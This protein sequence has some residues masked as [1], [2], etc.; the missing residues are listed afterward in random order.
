MLPQFPRLVRRT[1]SDENRHGWE[2][3]RSG[4]EVL[5]SFRCWPRPD[6]HDPPLPAAETLD[7]TNFSTAGATIALK[8]EVFKVGAPE[9]P[10]PPGWGDDDL[11]EWLQLPAPAKL[12]KHA[13]A[14]ALDVALATAKNGEI[15]LFETLDYGGWRVEC[16]VH[17]ILA[18]RQEV[19]PYAAKTRGHG[20]LA[21]VAKSRRLR[22]PT[23][24][25]RSLAGVASTNGCGVRGTLRLVAGWVGKW[26]PLRDWF[27]M[28]TDPGVGVDE[29]PSPGLPALFVARLGDGRLAE[30]FEACLKAIKKN[31][32]YRCTIA[33]ECLL[34]DCVVTGLHADGCI[35]P[36]WWTSIHDDSRSR[37]TVV[38]TRLPRVVIDVVVD[39]VDDTMKK[40]RDPMTATL[41]EK[42]T[43]ANVL[44]A[45]GTAL[46]HHG[47]LRRAEAVWHEGVKIFGFW[48]PE[49][50]GLDPGD[51]HF[52]E[53]EQ[54]RA[55]SI[56]LLLNEALL[57]RRRGALEAAELNCN[58]CI[59]NDSCHIKAIFRRGQIRIDLKKWDLARDDLRRVT[60]LGG[61]TVAADIDREL[62]RLRRLE[63][64]QDAKDCRY[65]H[66]SF[67]DDQEAL[68]GEKNGR[69]IARVREHVRLTKA[70]RDVST[71]T[72]A[73]R[74]PVRKITSQRVYDWT[75]SY[76]T[77]GRPAYTTADACQNQSPV[78]WPVVVDD[79]DAEL[80]ELSDEEG[81]ARRQANEDYYNA[82]IGIGTARVQI[83]SPPG[84][85]WADG[86]T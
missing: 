66:H 46:F 43:L 55:L 34:P 70:G 62:G 13:W 77:G 42:A 64:I 30:G 53:N 83:G 59:E 19:E 3:P 78:N 57:M 5:A 27:G 48:K 68:Y 60:N 4:Q 65:F 58:E 84:G 79:L 8:F 82:Q 1:L 63:R 39:D 51:Y 23:L 31:T 18:E 33:G 2:T 11:D 71:T 54:L 61:A 36:S 9:P 10:A 76:S 80:E 49:D 15:F 25:A 73:A 24:E 12:G 41:L 21:G 17:E 6:G 38:V 72:N 85:P 45:R 22:H 32:A 74:T 16:E 81:E 29:A 69:G 26:R 35:P 14:A 52:R 56:P 20:R 50:S 44:K 7:A 28:S 75:S 47:R 37:L 86:V 67:D 40:S